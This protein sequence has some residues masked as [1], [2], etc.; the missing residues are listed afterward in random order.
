MRFRHLRSVA[1]AMTVGLT[2]STGFSRFLYFDETAG[3][4]VID[5]AVNRNML[6]D[7]RMLAN[8]THVMK[9]ARRLIPN[10]MPFYKFA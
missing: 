2:W 7:Q 10:S 3:V 4:N 8:T 5:V 9:D 1:T 6:Y